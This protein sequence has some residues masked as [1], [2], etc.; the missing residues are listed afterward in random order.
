MTTL[1]VGSTPLASQLGLALAHGDPDGYARWPA[2]GGGDS[3]GGALTELTADTLA[4]ALR[5]QRVRAVLDA[6]DPFAEGISPLLEAVCV[7]LG[8]PHLRLAPESFDQL[9]EADS[10]HWV[11]S[12]AEAAEAV[13]GGADTPVVALEPLELCARIG[14]VNGRHGVSHRRFSVDDGPRPTW[15]REPDR[16]VHTASQ[17]TRLIEEEEATVLMAND[18]GDPRVLEVLRASGARALKV[19]MVRRP[20]RWRGLRGASPVVHDVVEALTWRTTVR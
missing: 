10:W 20:P 17:A 6:N 15:L 2:S 7:D 12:V 19:V 14:E 9:E 8:V 16:P 13:W 5:R 1:V 3:P 18:S 11:D 4:A